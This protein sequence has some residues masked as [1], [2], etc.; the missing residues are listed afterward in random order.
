MTEAAEEAF[1]WG[2]YLSNRDAFAPELCWGGFEVSAEALEVVILFVRR[3]LDENGHELVLSDE[4]D[5][6]CTVEG[7]SVF[8]EPRFL[9]ELGMR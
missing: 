1:G 5:D 6:I 9:H 2:V 8:N 3:C 4:V 7:V